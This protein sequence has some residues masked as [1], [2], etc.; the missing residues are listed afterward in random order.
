MSNRKFRIVK[1]FDVEGGE[2]P[3][4]PSPKL[5]RIQAPSTS[6]TISRI[7]GG[8]RSFRESY[9]G[10]DL[11]KIEV[12]TF[13]AHIRLS[14]N[15]ELKISLADQGD[16]IQCGFCSVYNLLRLVG[17]SERVFDLKDPIRL[18]AAK[19]R[20]EISYDEKKW[21]FD[22]DIIEFLKKVGTTISSMG[23]GD[24]DVKYTANEKEMIQTNVRGIH[25]N[26]FDGFIVSSNDHYKA[27]AN[28][29]SNFVLVDSLDNG[30]A[31]IVSENEVKKLL[32]LST[33]YI[34]L[35]KV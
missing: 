32:S 17:K 26:D 1:K 34:G 18:S 30:S 20:S 5:F 11:S 13:D 16:A 6:Q 7:V 9:Q 19:M 21:I 27:I 22:T 8:R 33:R 14:G 31:I 23:C 28:V 4:V 24:R 3:S 10:L 29:S 35:K 15:R 2:E 25:L 12:S